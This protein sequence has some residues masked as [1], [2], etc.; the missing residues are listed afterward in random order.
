MMH[1]LVTVHEGDDIT[2]GWQHA[3]SVELAL[4]L[5][6]EESQI[7]QHRVTVLPEPDGYW[8]CFTHECV[9]T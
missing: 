3:Y 1:I 2:G 6:S 5:T 8:Y 9:H 4:T 7:S